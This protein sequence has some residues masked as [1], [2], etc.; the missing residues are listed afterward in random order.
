MALKTAV[1]KCSHAEAK[2][3]ILILLRKKFSNIR[4]SHIFSMSVRISKM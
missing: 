3:Q 4:K 1:F 2:F